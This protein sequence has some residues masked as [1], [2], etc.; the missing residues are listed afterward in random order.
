MNYLDALEYLKNVQQEGTKL[1]IENIKNLID[2]L[3]FSLKGIRFIQVGGTNGKGS[4]AHFI[5]SILLAEGYRVGL[6]VSPHL[7]DIRERITVNKE[8]IPRAEFATSLSRVKEISEDL[9]EKR[10][11]ENMPTFFEHIFLT[12]I[13]YFYRSHADFVVLEVGLGGRLDA[14]STVIPRVSCITNISFDHTKTLG[15][16]ISDIA[17]EKAGIIK[18]STPVVCGCKE[19]SIANKVIRAESLKR[20]APFYNVIDS[21]NILK[22]NDRKEFF[23]CIYQ[24]D[25]DRYTFDV[26]LNGEHQTRNAAAAVKVIELLKRDGCAISKASIY[27]GVKNNFIAGRIERIDTPPPI[28]LDCSHNVE[29]VKAL[30]K[31]LL[32]REMKNLTLI[33]GVLRDKKYK[34]MIALLLPF[35]KNVI[36]TEP[37]SKRA[38]EAENLVSLFNQHNV[39]VIRDYHEALN[40]ARQL[41]ETILITGS[42]YLTGEMRNL[43]LGGKDEYRQVSG[44]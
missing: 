9:L 27:E 40:R 29:S 36:I 33:F 34:K 7:Q 14:T 37:L 32:Q 35:I 28:I 19:N 20:N 3:P 16:R 38:L 44:N 43:I 22:V 1:A 4:T 13:D 2:N 15:S 6:Y 18:N 30:Q 39:S 17:R 25:A 23:H 31:F 21:R 8:W 11:I 26:Y 24:T 12:S 5:T 41:K 42:L 10:M